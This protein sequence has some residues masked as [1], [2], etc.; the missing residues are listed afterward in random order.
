MILISIILAACEL[1]PKWRLMFELLRVMFPYII[2]VCLAAI[3]MGMLNARGHFFIPA[4][5]ASLLNIVMIASVFLLAP[6]MGKTLEEQIFALAIG[7]LVAGV[8][9]AAFQLPVL[10]KEG[11]RYQWV[12]PWTDPTVREVAGKMVIGSIGVAAFQINV[13]VTQI[14]SFGSNEHI[15]AEF[16]FAT[17][18]MELPQG[19]FGI[20][21]ATYL[22]T[23]LS[24]LAVEKK[25]NE[26]RS[27]LRQG[28]TY[29][30]FTNSLAS[31]LLVVMARPII[32]LVFEH[33]EFTSGDTVSVSAALMCLAPGLVA[34]SMVNIL[35]RAF[36]A[37]EDIKTPMKISMFC[38]GVNLLLTALFLFGL[39]MD[40]AGLAL[41]N[42]FTSFLN[43]SLLL[44]TLRKKLKRLELTAALSEIPAVLGAGVAAGALAWV[45]QWQWNRHFGHQGLP[46]RIGHVFV[47]MIPATV[48]Y[49]VIAWKCKVRAAQD[50]LDLALSRFKRKAAPLVGSHD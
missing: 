39:K 22:L 29:L 20:S 24:G 40:A 21:L 15:I 28:V 35:A 45:L 44:I 2:L 6:R 25:Y 10:R 48:L 30:L 41:A 33:G 32:R 27:T 50:V 23:T 17:R 14:M 38:L 4:I 19:V 11:Y 13:L 34:F 3:L 46:V 7:V 42:T 16:S 36:Y 37:L 5:G 18:L 49:F 26:F 1:D 31:I 9:Q 8:A 43:V 47:P 12:T